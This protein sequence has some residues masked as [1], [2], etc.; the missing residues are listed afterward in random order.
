MSPLLRVAVPGCASSLLLPDIF[1]TA[2]KRAV[3][4]DSGAVLPGVQLNAPGISRVPSSC[5]RYQR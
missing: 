3:A 2:R 5:A 1:L 4:I